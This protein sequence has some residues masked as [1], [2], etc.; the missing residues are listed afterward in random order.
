MSNDRTDREYC[1]WVRQHQD[2]T[3]GY[4]SIEALD[5]LAAAADEIER[6]RA[7]LLPFAALTHG[8]PEN[9]PAQCPLRIDS[10]PDRD[11]R[12]YEWIAYHGVGDDG[13]PLDGST[14]LPTVGEWREAAEAAVGGKR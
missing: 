6:L 3:D 9:W 11:G 1:V 5:R 4:T 14:L 2:V 12:L 10:G 8:I 7:A 13:L